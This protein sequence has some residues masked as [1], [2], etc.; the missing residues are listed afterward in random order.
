MHHRLLTHRQVENMNRF[1][2]KAIKL[3]L[4]AKMLANVSNSSSSFS[5]QFKCTGYSFHNYL[6]LVHCRRKL[7]EN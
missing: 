6:L 3:Q 4:Q 7:Q 2:T 1:F 5:C